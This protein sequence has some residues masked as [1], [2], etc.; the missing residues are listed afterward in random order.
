MLIS[1]SI[2]I[3]EVQQ[4][5]IRLLVQHKATPPDPTWE[6]IYL[7][8]PAE[9]F[10][11]LFLIGFPQ[12]G[13]STL[14]KSI[15]IETTNAI[16]DL[17]NRFKQVS[18][19]E[20][21]T[22]GIIASDIQSERF[23]SMTIYD[24]AGHSEFYT[25]HD[26]ALRSVLA[27]SPSSIIILVADMS[28]G[29]EHF[30][31][32]ILHWCSFAS[33]LFDCSKSYFPF[34]IIVGSFADKTMSHA[35]Q[36]CQADID[37]MKSNRFFSKF[38]LK[39]FVSLDCRYPVSPGMTNLR[40]EVAECCQIL[41]E[42]RI[43]RFR[44]HCFLVA[45][46]HKFPEETAVTI[47]D[48]LSAVLHSKDKTF[49]SIFTYVQNASSISEFC[50]ELNGRGN[51]LFLENS[52]KLAK[53]WIVLQK[54]ILLKR[55][56]GLIFAPVDHKDHK[57]LASNTGI[58][59]AS[60][61]AK[62]FPDLDCG[63]IM[64]LMT[65]LQFCHEVTDPEILKQLSIS[66]H[67]SKYLFFPSLVTVAA[68]SGIWEDRKEFS[69]ESVWSLM[70]GDDE[71]FLSTT[72]MHVTIHHFAFNHAMA[73]RSTSPLSLSIHRRCSVWKNGIYWRS[74][75]GL[76]V[77]FELDFKRVAL[78]IRA[79][80]NSE[81]EAVKLRSQLISTILRMKQEFCKEAKVMECFVSND[82]ILFPLCNDS[83]QVP[84][85]DITQ[86]LIECKPY[87]FD[88]QEKLVKLNPLLFFEPF[89]NLGESILNKLF[90]CPQENISNDYLLR[91]AEK[92]YPSIDVFITLLEIPPP[93]FAFD[94]SSGSNVDKFYRVLEYWRDRN[95][96]Y[97]HL[98]AVLAKYSIF[99]GRNPLSLF[100]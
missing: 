17:A 21:S 86:S 64:S 26:I 8:K 95:P 73:P 39:C 72:F 100:S 99:A 30:K 43:M 3:E 47:N 51:L 91:F 31:E 19:V 41:K 75:Q 2:I 6:K 57:P 56:N 24:L 12:A 94:S 52:S 78:Y 90:S 15:Q 34:L 92:V 5:A 48:V 62:V 32:A 97:S 53:S 22:C 13:K 42:S 79:R 54:D 85:L 59:P 23:G 58:V 25:S 29:R 33:N 37:N 65:H 96:T 67:D 63:L 61:L 88:T 4:K 70:C 44:D 27:G 35:I 81:I 71:Q 89:T 87:C 40:S 1:E 46:T 16:K 28:K 7:H 49:D 82:N 60:K 36:S 10:S 66:D 38:K 50:V 45:I 55:I 74:L 11:K 9:A 68:P 77:I 84:L 14:A 83:I 76:D 98:C 80:K 93:A 69:Y 18:G 20:K